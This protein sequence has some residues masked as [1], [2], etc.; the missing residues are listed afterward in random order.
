M[1]G[2]SPE[3]SLIYYFVPEDHET[4]QSLN[5]F[6]IAKAI[7]E[8]DLK[9]IQEHFPLQGTYDFKF[10][11]KFNRKFV[12]VV[13]EKTK[14]KESLAVPVS[15]GKIMLKANRV[16]WMPDPKVASKKTP[17]NFVASK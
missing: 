2:S 7:D 9:D 17:S 4:E 5:A 11:V 10:R 3:L 15:G 8:V 1:S 6:A 14:G 16:S 12:Y 13:P